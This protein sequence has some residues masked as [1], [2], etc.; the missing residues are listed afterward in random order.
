MEARVPLTLHGRW[1]LEVVKAVHNWENR[2]VVAGAQLGDGTYDG[3]VGTNI[4]VDGL[5]QWQLRGEYQ[6]PD[7]PGVWRSSDRAVYRPFAVGI[8][9][10]MEMPDGI[11]DTLLGT[12]YMGVRVTNSW[13]EVFSVND[14]IDVGPRG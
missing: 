11:F 2:F 5:P 7:E 10:L 9:D 12:Y 13:G 14:A 1:Q 3:A 6:K 4:T 8:Q